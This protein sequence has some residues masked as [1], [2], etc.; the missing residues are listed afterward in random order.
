M[1]AVRFIAIAGGS[2]S[3]KTWLAR[4]LKRRFEKSAGILALDDF[5]R[6]LSPPPPRE[7]T[8]VNFDHPDAIAWELFIQCLNQI[9]L[10]EPTRLPRYDFSRHTRPAR[11]WLWNPRPVVLVEGLW[12]LHRADLR[13]LWSQ[14][15]FVECPEELRLKR[16]IARD[17]AERGRS[18]ASVRRQFY[19]DVAPMHECHVAPQAQYAG[20]RVHSP[21]SAGEFDLL[22]RY[23]DGL[24]E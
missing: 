23:L 17:Q 1:Q 9:Q 22:A 10:G 21:V 16:R 5:Y 6:D 20:L 19:R 13:Q 15:V 2:G 7:R 12:L 18:A 3:G 11:M 8:R 24:S 4:R 14:S